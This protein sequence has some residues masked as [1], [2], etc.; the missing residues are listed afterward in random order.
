M[1]SESL[2]RILERLEGVRS[3][4]NGYV[5]HCPVPGHGKGRGDRN[6]SLSISVG[7][8]GKV[9][10]NCFAGCS[11]EDVLGAI[12]L[13]THN[14]RGEG[15]KVDEPPKQGNPK[16][17]N[18]WIAKKMW[19]SCEVD[20]ERIGEYLRSRGLSGEVPPSLRFHPRLAYYDE[21]Q[22]IGAYPAIIAAVRDVS[23]KGVAVHRTYLDDKD[24]GK[25]PVA[26]PKKLL[27]SMK[28]AAIRLAKSE[29]TLALTEGI[30]TALA[31][32]EAT[33]MPA[34]SCVSSSGLAAVE[35]PEVV[36]YVEIWADNDTA[37]VK[38][39]D[40]L[41]RRLYAE[42]R[43]VSVLIPPIS[44]T[45]WLD[46]L[47]DAD[48][49]AE[50]MR[51]VQQ[52]ANLWEEEASEDATVLSKNEIDE[53]WA[54]VDE[55]AAS[56]NPTLNVLGS[57]EMMSCLS[58]L[59]KSYPGPWGV[60]KSKLK[61]KVNL[62]DLERSTKPSNDGETKDGN[63]EKPSQ[64]D[65]LIVAV[66]HE[67]AFVLTPREEFY[68]VIMVDEHR[69]VLRARGRAFERW[70]T[71]KFHDQY[72]ETI[73][74]QAIKDAI[75]LLEARAELD[76]IRE[77]VHVRLAE[78]DG[79]IYLDLGDSD[80]N[81]V[82]VTNDGWRIVSDPPVYFHRRRG[83]QSLPIPEAGRSL[84]DLRKLINIPDD[85]DWVLLVAWI[86][87]SLRPRGPHPIM[88][89]QGEQGSGKSTVARMLKCLIDP[90]V[91]PIRTPP[92]EERDL[93][94]AGTNGWIMAFD[95]ISKLPWWLSDALC[96]I[97]TGGGFS[98]RELYTDQDE[99]I[100][101]AQRPIILNGIE[102]FVNRGDL[103]DRAIT[104]EVPQIPEDRRRAESEIWDDFERAHAGI[105]GAL[106]NI[107]SVGLKNQS[108]VSLQTLPRMADFA[109]FVIAAEPAL[110]WRTGSFMDAYN[111]KRRDTEG[112]ILDADTVGAE[113]LRF[114]VDLPDGDWEGTA[115]E[116]LEE[117]EGVASAKTVKSRAWPGSPSVLSNRIKRLAPL[118]R[119]N[120]IDVVL[121]EREGG[122]GRRLVRV[123]RVDENIS[124]PKS[125]R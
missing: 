13:S 4:G 40:N 124:A 44:G 31:V 92:R 28:G 24:R 99:I 9:L 37:G 52:K 61:G 18:Y 107:L 6:P 116:L 11:N 115:T 63:S 100:F 25:A 82:M 47:N 80:W 51:Q 93:M 112:S 15:G 76:G 62:H 45:D 7:D 36:K 85:A 67:A 59:R 49:G 117:L 111:A 113:L 73:G 89:L 60:V 14:L 105:L 39:A 79:V 32:L 68:A 95:N 70:L 123:S 41:A 21:G 35:M 48:Y 90:G 98:T 125:D 88:I 56:D 110:P 121:G 106:L 22:K 74:R 42:G 119:E 102:Q 65:L 72:G 34:W 114:A 30:E 3:S 104:L 84:E 55:A 29:D 83:M 10:M 12:G 101:D 64:A 43:E 50:Y 96:R 81:V 1:V 69:E 54:S 19:D 103:A 87:G 8:S 16:G 2:T 75:N 23:G 94:I 71:R 91:A 58:L 97:A 120:S 53:I 20:S 38:A 118:L 78:Y 17:K 122:S 27:N 33:D 77:D 26:E 57:S 108:K 46:T 109:K 5:A 86:L 66:K